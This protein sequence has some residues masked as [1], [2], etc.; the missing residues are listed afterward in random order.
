MVGVNISLSPVVN[1]DIVS[2][3]GN[4]VYSQ[5]NAGSN[6]SYNVSNLMLAGADAGNYY[7]A[8][9]TSFTGTN[10]VITQ[11]TVTLSANQVYSGSTTLTNVSIGNLVGAESL[12]Y[13]ANAVSKN[14]QDNGANYIANMTLGNGTNG[15]LGSNYQLPVLNVAN[16][17]VT[18]TRLN[19]VTWTGGATGDWFDPANWAGGAV[20]DLN[21]V[22]NVVIPSGATVTFNNN[23]TLPAQAGP[24]LIDSLGGAGGNLA[25]QLGTLNVGSGGVTLNNLTL[26]GGNFSSQGAVNL[27]S[28]NQS[29]GNITVSDSFATQSYL[30]SNG[31]ASI[32]GNLTATNVTLANG[33]T[34]V[35]ANLITSNQLDIGGGDLTVAG[36]IN[37]NSYSQSN[38]TV[39]VNGSLNTQA[40]TQVAGNTTIQGNIDATSYTQSNGNTQTAGS[41]TASN[42]SL[43]GG[44]TNV[45]GNL[46]VN[47]AYNQTGGQVSVTG[48]NNIS[49]NGSMTLGN[50]VVG[51]LLNA[52]SASGNIT[53]TAGTVMSITGR[54]SFN[55]LLGT[56]SLG[57][58]NSF[59]GGVTIN[60]KNSGRNDNNGDDQNGN[61]IKVP[62]D[63]WTFQQYAVYGGTPI[64]VSVPK[65]QISKTEKLSN[66]FALNKEVELVSENFIVIP[67]DYVSLGVVTLEDSLG[68]A[69][70]ETSLPKQP[71]ESSKPER[72]KTSSPAGF[73]P[74]LFRPNKSN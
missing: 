16:A 23:I 7:L 41:L 13:S 17:P 58:N 60:D 51:G 6:I 47:R 55:A 34:T 72:L 43:S 35:F 1:G 14:V 40:Y 70:K 30:Q 69:A 50:L 33:S 39:I 36:D 4:G 18:I 66:T 29:G 21:N 54:A 12:T 38:G 42:V 3:A 73:M 53:Q 32:T 68:A 48:T 46:L 67:D 20:P 27:S 61:Q 45:Q 2:T 31:S 8:N 28:F 9:G 22:A 25:Q 44:A 5:A 65:L 62:V 24:V 19:S 52:S 71:S 64:F 63:P 59:R 15:G 56:V 26:S 10:G 11:R 37:T 74:V 49:T 57:S